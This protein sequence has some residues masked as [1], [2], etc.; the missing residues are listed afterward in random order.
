MKKAYKLGSD[1]PFFLSIGLLLLLY[2]GLILALVIANIHEV[3]WQNMMLTYA[4][5][6]VQSALRLTLLTSTISV[7]LALI[8]AVPIS[9]IL[10]RFRFF[11]RGLI[12]AILDIPVV[13]PPLVIGLS[14]L[15]LFNKIELFNDGSS[16]E[17]WLNRRGLKVTFSAAAVVLAQFTVATA[18]AVRILKNIFEKIDPRAEQ[19]ALTMGCNNSR[20]FWDVA[21]PQAR[22]GIVATAVMVWARAMGEF[23]SI[24]VFA[25]AT[26]GRTEVLATSVF[27]ELN[28]GNLAGAAAISLLLIFISLVLITIVRAVSRTKISS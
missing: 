14:L 23:G 26:R 4:K 5:P 11:G 16:V 10:T 13:L 3:N 6:E 18:Y 15:I 8:F 19:V 22:Q 17:E 24:L 7:L 9:Y 1:Q 28:I 20:A 25:G 12:D 27:L 2:I 21:L